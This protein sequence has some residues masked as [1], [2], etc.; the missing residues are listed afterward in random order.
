MIEQRLSRVFRRHRLLTIS[1]VTFMLVSLAPAV[2]LQASYLLE[3][4]RRFPTR[5]NMNTQAIYPEDVTGDGI[6]DLV[7]VFWDINPTYDDIVETMVGAGDGTFL[8]SYYSQLSVNNADIVH[9]TSADLN[10]DGD[11]DL[12]LN[13][14]TDGSGTYRL[15]TMLGGGDGRFT[16]H[17]TVL[18]EFSAGMIIAA[19]F[20]GDGNVDIAVGDNSPSPMIRFYTGDGSGNLAAGAIVAL[21]EYYRSLAAGD[22]DNDGDIDL[23]AGAD[24]TTNNLLVN[25]GSGAFT[26]QS[27][28]APNES[29]NMLAGDLD[30]DGIDDLVVCDSRTFCSLWVYFGS[31]GSLF[32][33]YDEYDIGAS[34]HFMA[35]G[36]ID[37][38]GDLDIALNGGQSPVGGS[39]EMQVTVMLNDGDGNLSGPEYYFRQAY[40]IKIADM[41]GDGFGDALTSSTN[42]RGTNILLGQDD[43]SFLDMEDILPGEQPT[44]LCSGD[45]DGDGDV[46]LVVTD[47]DMQVDGAQVLLNNG[48][49][50]FASPVVYAGGDEPTYPLL[51]DLDGDQLPEL[52]VVDSVYDSSSGVVVW[53]NAGGGTFEN[54]Q[55][56]AVGTQSIEARAGDLDGDGDLDLAVLTTSNFNVLINPGTGI[57][58]DADTFASATG[59]H[60]LTLGDVDGDG[61]LDALMIGTTGDGDGP[62]LQRNNG[63]GFFT[64]PELLLSMT[65]PNGLG[66]ADLDGDGDLDLAVGDQNDNQIRVRFNDGSGNFGNGPVTEI[67]GENILHILTGDLNLDGIIDLVPGCEYS[68]DIAI[69]RGYGYG[70][71][72]WREIFMTGESPHFMTLADF[73]GSGSLDVATCGLF[74]L[75]TMIFFNSLVTENILA[76]GPGRGEFNPTLVRVFPAGGSTPMAQ[77]SAYSVDRWGVNVALGRLDAEDG[78][79]VLT[80]AGPGAVFGPH[81]RGFSLT[82]SPLPGLS[83]L[84][85]GTNKYGV[86]VAGGDLDNDGYHEIVTGAGPGAVFGPHVR[87]WNWDGSGTP[88]PIPGVSYFAYGTPKWGVNVCCGDIDGDGYDEIV[89]GAGPGAVYGP[90]VRGWNCDGGGATAISAVSFLAYGTNKY[91]VNVCCGD[92]DGDGIDEMVTGAGP[93]AVFGPHVRAWNWDGSG[94]AQAIAGVSFFAYP[95]YTKWGANVPAATWTMT[96]WTRSSP[97]RGRG[98]TTWPGCGASTTTTGASPR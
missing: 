12:I 5:T 45:A 81:V 63:S 10:N 32:A 49:G 83:F 35:L 41:N 95:T 87:G 71:F 88:T 36:D 2:E 75:G 84:A 80:G 46:D 85:Y 58:G 61:D 17:D 6:P 29:R 89:T 94:V 43:G 98:P 33:A 67:V 79:E 96:A 92:I 62:V 4:A 26:I 48:D 38:D 30:G 74:D 50:T 7:L 97:G 44:G 37:N 18:L 3:S 73:D 25:N 52:I 51:A 82:G 23:A 20:T 53:H 69:M 8:G 42:G 93:G 39:F 13:I 9:S 76:T 54:Q 64:S 15:I 77:W 22:F 40:N 57:F 66:L 70:N 28:N 16:E 65:E 59:A 68:D 14:D 78:P 56:Y 90:H 21:P 91:G 1:L 27:F 47:R 11:L 34:A 60:H 86:N 31:A 19:D 72:E 24:D 55:S